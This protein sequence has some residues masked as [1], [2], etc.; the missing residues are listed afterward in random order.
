MN[1]N[2]K[3]IQQKKIKSHKYTLITSKSTIRN[4]LWVSWAGSFSLSHFPTFYRLIWKPCRRQVC[5][6]VEGAILTLLPQPGFMYIY[7]GIYI[8]K[9]AL[10]KSLSNIWCCLYGG[11]L[12]T[13]GIICLCLC[14]YK[15]IL[16]SKRKNPKNI[17]YKYV[18]F[19]MKMKIK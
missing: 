8:H 3:K 2:K 18:T 5:L 15:F 4:A 12:L 17:Y 14:I 6:F 13:M 1:T 7:F 16:R 9:C 11:L 19:E 10:Y